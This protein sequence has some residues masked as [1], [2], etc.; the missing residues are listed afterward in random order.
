MFTNIGRKIMALAKVLCWAGIILSVILGIVYISRGGEAI[1]QSSQYYRNS[2][3]KETGTALQT[4]GW[5]VLIAG[6]LISW[7]SSFVLYGFGELVA[8]AGSIDENRGMGTSGS[9]F[10]VAGQNQSKAQGEDTAERNTCAESSETEN[11]QVSERHGVNPGWN[12][13]GVKFV[14]CPDCGE[15]MTLDFIR[16]RRQC[17]NCGCAY[18]E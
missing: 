9:G 18:Q 10:S 1:K 16:V 3:L 17:C 4:A 11:R 12:Y 2:T 14:T 5:I 15:Q 13:D 7:I 8:R 6:P